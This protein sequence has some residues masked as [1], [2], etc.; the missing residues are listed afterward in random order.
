MGDNQLW[1][2]HYYLITLFLLKIRYANNDIAWTFVVSSPDPTP[3]R[4]RGS[5]THRALFEVHRMQHVMWR[6]W[7]ALFRH[8]NASVTLTCSNRWLARGVNDNHMIIICKPHGDWCD[9]IQ[10]CQVSKIQKAL[11]AY[12][13]LSALWGWGL[14]TGLELLP[15]FWSAV[16]P[17]VLLAV[18]SPGLPTTGPVWHHSATEQENKYRKVWLISAYA[19]H[20]RW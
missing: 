10:T 17:I 11:D 3:K 7:Q 19:Y 9:R 2:W 4:R 8:G 1:L 16:L 18:S 15:N 20:S 13:T 14:G 6:S 5:G 12:Q